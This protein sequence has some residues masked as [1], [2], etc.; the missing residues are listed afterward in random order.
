[1][2]IPPFMN[3]GSDACYVP[4]YV[5]IEGTSCILHVLGL[6]RG[7]YEADHILEGEPSDKDGLSDF[8]EILLL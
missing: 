3:L 1:M 2:F 5:S 6:S 7:C 8:E 4:N